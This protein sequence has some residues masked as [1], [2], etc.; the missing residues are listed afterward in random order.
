MQL[1]ASV[2]VP[3][4]PQTAIEFLSIP[5]TF[6]DLLLVFSARGTGD[7]KIKFN[8][9]GTLAS[10]RHLFGNGSGVGSGGASDGYAGR[11]APT[12]AT[13]ST[14]G[15]TQIYIPNY[16][17]SATK[18]YSVD[19][20]DENNGTTAFQMIISGVWGVTDPISSL[21]ISDLG[22]GGLQFVEYSSASLYGILAGSSGGVVVS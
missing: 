12:S 2:T 11:S 5:T 21:E 8:G 7:V 20:V 18:A 9:S 10:R 22:G 19:S 17:S 6:T 16:R 4:T 15:N 3:S 14:F 1:I 13:A